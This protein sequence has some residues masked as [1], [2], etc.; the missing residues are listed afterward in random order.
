MLEKAT[1]FVPEASHINGIRVTIPAGNS[2]PYYQGE[3]AS[4][5]W[6]ILFEMGVHINFAHQTF[7]W[8]NNGAIVHVCIAGFSLINEKIK[9]ITSYYDNY[10][11]TERIKAKNINEY[12]TDAPIANVRKRRSQISN[13]PEM[14]FGSMANDNGNFILN[15]KEKEELIDTY[16]KLTDFIYS[17]IGS[18]E[19]LR[20]EQR[21]I[22]YLK[23]IN[24]KTL[25]SN[26]DIKKRVQQVQEYRLASKRKKT[27]E[28]ANTP[29]LL[30]EDRVSFS[31]KLIIPR[32]SST[33]RPYMPIGFVNKYTIIS[34]SA[35]Q[36]VNADLYIFG[37]LQSKMHTIWVKSVAGRLKSDIRYS[38]T[39]VYNTFVFP[40]ATQKQK[41]YIKD[42]SRNLLKIRQDLLDKGNS[43]ADLYDKLFMPI[44]LQN[45]HKK[46]D[47]AIEETY[48]KEPFKDNNDRLAFLI[49][50]YKNL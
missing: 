11:K 3:Q 36:L 22:L 45:A 25:R 1:F 34:D 18:K 27:R 47:K 23:D 49:R 39:L 40:K 33:N 41:N 30:G 35:F 43:I 2:Y 31:N 15:S 9:T 14:N 13:M 38:N 24:I 42:L 29:I 46:L 50:L 48:R 28:L 4:T 16:P 8:D 12:L 20:N 6:S 5:L 44:E 32:V 17:F 21:Y 26:P 19:Y 10:S 7:K 37:V